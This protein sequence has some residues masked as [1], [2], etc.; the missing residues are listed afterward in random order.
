MTL[1]GLKNIFKLFNFKGGTAK[2]AEN[3]LPKEFLESEKIARAVYSPFNFHKKHSDRL[4]PNFYKPNVP[5]NET[6]TE[7]VSVNR[8]D[9]TTPAFL[10]KLAKYFQSEQRRY[11]GFAILNVKEIKGAGWGIV[12]TPIV[13]PRKIEEKNLFHS[14][15]KLGYM[16]K[17][18][19]Q[20]PAEYSQK[21]KSL[22][23]KVRYYEDS[24]VNSECFKGEE[25]I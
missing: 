25:L 22:A 12:Y 17:K 4:N 2:A 14:D 1:K 15:I 5:K 10:K 16:V 9:Y 7:D 11:R 20:L 3:L 6:E 24:D 8:L 13:N 18:G 19:E 23:N 21:V